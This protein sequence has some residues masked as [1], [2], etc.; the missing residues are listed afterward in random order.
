MKNGGALRLMSI[1]AANDDVMTIRCTLPLDDAAR[2]A[3]TPLIAGMI[4]SF[5]LFV[6]L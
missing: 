2:I 5:S 1:T 6:V 3:R 4:S